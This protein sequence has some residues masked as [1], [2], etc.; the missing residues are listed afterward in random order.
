MIPRRPS[1]TLLAFVSVVLMD[2]PLIPVLMSPRQPSFEWPVRKS[3]IPQDAADEMDVTETSAA[4][5]PD[6]RYVAFVDG[7]RLRIRDLTRLDV[8]DPQVRGTARTPA[9]SPDGGAIAFVVD[10]KYIFKTTVAGDTPVK[11]CDLPGGLVTGLAWQPDRTILVNVTTGE[12]PTGRFFRTKDDGG[13]LEPWLPADAGAS[14][15]YLRGLTDGTIIYLQRRN[16]NA[17]TVVERPGTEP[18]T[19]D[20]GSHFGATYSPTG[21]L[22]YGIGDPPAIWAVPFSLDPGLITGPAFL[23]AE[24]GTAPSVAADG[25]LAYGRTTGLRQLRW[26]HRDGTMGAAAGEAQD[27]VY[28]PAIAPDGKHV[29]AVGLDH[30]VG[31][32]WIHD[33]DKPHAR[34]VISG[35]NVGAPA[36]HPRVG[37]LAFHS[38]GWDILAVDTR[39]GEP[40]PVVNTARGEYSPYWSSDGRHLVYCQLSARTKSDIWMTE[41]GREP[42]AVVA[43]ASNEMMPA[44]SPDG[45]LLAYVTDETG[46]FEVFVRTFPDGQNPQRVSLNGGINPRWGGDELFFV[47]GTTLMAA[48]VRL[49]ASVQVTSPTRLFTLDGRAANWPVFDTLDGKRFVVA[50]SVKPHANGVAVVQNWVDEF[51][52][53]R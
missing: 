6:G 43:T 19:L 11:V 26:F 42:R 44:L 4:I 52:R 39:G 29:A 18:K 1:W 5:S 8:I 34:R 23:V 37:R 12:P 28:S 10:Q 27:N 3:I 53:P 38:G 41:D 32:I 49:Q 48:T 17:E 16:R 22:L 13:S 24:Y 15:F 14:V 33:V 35:A 25:T 51:A 45:R 20:L 2:L 21:H 40:Q 9:W 47:K 30:G 36:W 50:H 31:G 7:A 46:G